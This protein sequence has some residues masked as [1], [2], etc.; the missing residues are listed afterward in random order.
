MATRKDKKPTPIVG[1]THPFLQGRL[2]PTDEGERRFSV[3]VEKGQIVVSFG[4][5][6]SWFAVPPAT[7]VAPANLLLQIAKEVHESGSA[8]T[9]PG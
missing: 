8:S 2:N 5:P 4:K 9:P 7:A 6:V 1:A 3:H